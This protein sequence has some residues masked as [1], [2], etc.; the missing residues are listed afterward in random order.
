MNPPEVDPAVFS[1]L[2]ERWMER[3]ELSHLAQVET[4]LASAPFYPSDVIDDCAIAAATRLERK[5]AVAIEVLMLMAG[6]AHP[7]SRA[8]AAVIISRLALYAPALWI[9]LIRHLATD[10]NWE[11]RRYAARVFDSTEKFDGAA[12][13]HLEFVMETLQTWIQDK[14]YLVRHA[15]TQFLLGYVKR[16][17]AFAE[18]LLGMLDPLFDDLSE[19]VRDGAAAAM[20]AVGK[21]RPELALSFI[22]L[23]LDHLREFEGQTYL[24]ALD[25]PFADCRPEWKARL[26]TALQAATP[27][28]P[29]N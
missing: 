20:R 17:P 11:V 21:V 3:P 6:S 14:D 15:A 28:N 27:I 18:K 5:P 7:Q 10:E 1:A 8:V 22:E 29:D 19:Y 13:F 12:E 26:V 4:V 2:I 24:T 9:D 16:H 25:H 23:K